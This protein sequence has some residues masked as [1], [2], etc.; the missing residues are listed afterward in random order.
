VSIIP[1]GGVHNPNVP[2]LVD[3]P[4]TCRPAQQVMRLSKFRFLAGLEVKLYSDV[5]HHAEH[6]VDAGSIHADMQA[7]QEGWREEV[8]GWLHE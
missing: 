5:P 1:P 3:D 2:G 4:L 7:S 6:L 8:H